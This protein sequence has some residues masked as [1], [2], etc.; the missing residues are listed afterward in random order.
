M[1][2]FIYCHITL[3]VSGVN[4]TDNEEYIKLELQPLVGILRSGKLAS[5]IV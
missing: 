1:Q 3:N 4:H 2:I 5:Q